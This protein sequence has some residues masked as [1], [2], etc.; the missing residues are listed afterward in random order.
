MI[1][2]LWLA[3]AWTVAGPV[4][5]QFPTLRDCQVDVAYARVNRDVAAVTDCFLVVRPA[6]ITPEQ[7]QGG[8]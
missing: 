1:T 2:E 4:V 6:D 7:R 8:K 3:I 5:G